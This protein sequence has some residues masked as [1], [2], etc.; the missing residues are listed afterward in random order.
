LPM[1]FLSR[2]LLSLLGLTP[3]AVTAGAIYLEITLA[4][5]ILIVLMFVAGAALRGAGDTRTP[6][7]V[8]GF[9]NVINAVLAVELVFGGQRASGILSGFLSGLTRLQITV[10][11]LTWVPEMGVAGSAWAAAIARGIGTLILL[12]LF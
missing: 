7:F 9:I 8:T 10:P 11:G 3:A 4:A 5:A 1:A 12:S 6:M 2:P